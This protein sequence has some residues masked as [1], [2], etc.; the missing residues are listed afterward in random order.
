MCTKIER[1]DNE[2]MCTHPDSVITN[3]WAYAHLSWVILNSRYY[4]SLFISTSVC[5]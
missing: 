3:M 2:P 4:A 1:M 5:L